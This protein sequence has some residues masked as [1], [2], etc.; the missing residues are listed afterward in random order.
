MI[1]LATGDIS[2][3]GAHARRLAEQRHDSRLVWP[4][5]LRVLRAA[6][7]EGSRA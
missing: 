3:L 5:Y 4:R 6:A 7:S 2:H 1:R